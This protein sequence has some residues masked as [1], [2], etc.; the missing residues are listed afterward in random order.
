MRSGL[1]KGREEDNGLAC[2]SDP[3][4]NSAG[5]GKMSLPLMAGTRS[6]LGEGREEGI[7]IGIVVG[8]GSS[9]VSLAFNVTLCAEHLCLFRGG[10][11]FDYGVEPDQCLTAKSERENNKEKAVGV[12]MNV[13]SGGDCSA[14]VVIEI[15]LKLTV[16]NG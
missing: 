5:G 14:Q 3:S 11:Y 7:G 16:G 12:S 1:G 13:K 2:W 10:V 6:G 4:P 8:S 9:S 15:H